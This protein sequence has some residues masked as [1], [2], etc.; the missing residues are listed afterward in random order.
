MFDIVNK[1]VITYCKDG[2]IPLPTLHNTLRCCSLKKC[3]ICFN[4]TNRSIINLS[5]NRR[6]ENWVYTIKS[7][8]KRTVHKLIQI[9]QT[10]SNLRFKPSKVSLLLVFENEMRKKKEWTERWIRGMECGFLSYNWRQDVV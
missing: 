6:E 9:S 2:L 3:P 1:H 5:K 8:R 10:D 4:E 7:V